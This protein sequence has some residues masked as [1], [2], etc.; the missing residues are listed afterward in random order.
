MN[1]YEYIKLTENVQR[2]VIKMFY[3]VNHCF[4]IMNA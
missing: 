1:T 2:L 3:Q 4:F